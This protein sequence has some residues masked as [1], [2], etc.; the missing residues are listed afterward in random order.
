MIRRSRWLRQQKKKAALPVM[1]VRT[2]SMTFCVLYRRKM[3]FFCTCTEELPIFFLCLHFHKEHTF[4]CPGNISISDYKW[5][6]FSTSR[7][8]ISFA[9]LYDILNLFVVSILNIT[10]LS[11]IKNKMYFVDGIITSSFVI[12]I[13]ICY[14]LISTLAVCRKL[15]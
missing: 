6:L 1:N 4:G 5:Y 3:R 9:I 14:T 7:L 15:L 2:R 8:N 12:C 11:Y 10:Y 13:K